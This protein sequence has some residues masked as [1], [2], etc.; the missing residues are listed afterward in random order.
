MQRR[1]FIQGLV[2]AIAGRQLIVEA[3]D[4]D[5]AAFTAKPGDTTVVQAAMKADTKRTAAREVKGTT[6][7]IRL[8]DGTTFE[9]EVGELNISPMQRNRIDVTM[10]TEDPDS[11]HYITGLSRPPEITL[12]PVGPV[13]IDNEVHIG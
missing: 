7:L 10:M 13:R 11:K 8:P 1:S 5:I 12:T 4:A 6:C 3:T 2:A 9:F